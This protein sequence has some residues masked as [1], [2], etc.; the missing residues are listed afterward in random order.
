MLLP[1]KMIVQYMDKEE[2][3]CDLE[4]CDHPKFKGVSM[5]HIIRGESTGGM[6]SCH[7]V[8]VMPG[9]C[10]E[11]HTHEDNLEIHEVMEGKGTCLIDQK[12]IFY[13]RGIAAIIP[14]GTPHMV[15]AGEKG[16]LLMARFSPALI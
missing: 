12:E 10:L 9:C 16:I 2:N 6:L 4:W 15:K 13:Q 5:K 1:E 11:L 8:R 7:M 14:K 3:I